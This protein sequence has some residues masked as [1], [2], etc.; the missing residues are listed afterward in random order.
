MWCNEV[1]LCVGDP[2][3]DDVN[4]L[5]VKFLR[6]SEFKICQAFLETLAYS[7]TSQL[8]INKITSVSDQVKRNLE[9]PS[10]NKLVKYGH[11]LFENV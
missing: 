5:T 10:L 4:A 7:H 6:A 8:F 1:D 3:D 9:I 2:L 11:R